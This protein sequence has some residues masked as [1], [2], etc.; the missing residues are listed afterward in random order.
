MFER[1][2]IGEEILLEMEKH[3]RKNAF[4]KKAKRDADRVEGIELLNEAAKCF[5]EAGLT[6]E[7]EAITRLAEYAVTDRS[8]SNIDSAKAIANIKDHGH[9]LNLA[10]DADISVEEDFE[11]EFEEPAAE[12]E[13]LDE[14]LNDPEIAEEVAFNV[15]EEDEEGEEDVPDLTQLFS[16]V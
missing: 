14:Y 11:E 9:M 15:E 2:T 7:A 1:E 12:G 6:K 16:G 8:T 5:E 3:F 10:D 4:D 13:L